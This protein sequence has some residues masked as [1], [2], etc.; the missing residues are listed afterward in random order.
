MRMDKGAKLEEY[1]IVFAFK[2]SNSDFE[3]REIIYA[4]KWF[5]ALDKFLSCLS[6]KVAKHIK[7]ISI[8]TLIDSK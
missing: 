4:R 3:L 1:V 5:E 6:D 8:T 7:I 2:Y